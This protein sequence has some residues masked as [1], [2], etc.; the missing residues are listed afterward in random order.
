MSK[1]L[2]T[3]QAQTLF[4]Y[5]SWVVMCM[6]VFVAFMFT[7]WFQRVDS[8]PNV[9]LILRALGGALGVTGVPASL[10]IWFGMAA[11]CIRVDRSSLSTKVVWFVIFFATASFGAAAY[12]FWVYRRLVVQTD[13]AV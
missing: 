4:F 2:K 13:S 9:D 1:W 10:I 11:F 12:F 7:P 5:C 3:E 8:Q 6:G